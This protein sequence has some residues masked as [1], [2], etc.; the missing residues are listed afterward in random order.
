[1]YTL[2]GQAV[3]EADFLAD[4]DAFQSPHHS[5]IRPVYRCGQWT[6]WAVYVRGEAVGKVFEP[7]DYKLA[8]ILLEQIRKE[9][10]Q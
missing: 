3:S 6:G 2:N 9:S 1:M 4:E 5:Y 10:L 8:A 7:G